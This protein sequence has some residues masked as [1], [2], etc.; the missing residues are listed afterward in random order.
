MI[1]KNTETEVYR[2][3]YCFRA[4][5]Y[6]LHRWAIWVS[7]QSGGP[8][9][10][11]WLTLP[12]QGPTAMFQKRRQKLHYH[13]WSTLEITQHPSSLFYWWK[14][15]LKSSGQKACQ[16][17][18]RCVFKPRQFTFWAQLY[19]QNSFTPFPR[20]L[21]FHYIMV[22]GLK[23]RIFSSK[24]NPSVIF[25]RSSS[26]DIGFW[27]QSLSMCKNFSQLWCR[28]AICLSHIPNT[29]WWD[30][31][32]IT[33]VDAPV[34]KGENKKHDIVTG[35]CGSEIQLGMCCQFLAEAQSF[36]QGVFLCGSWL[37][38]LHSWFYPLSHFYF[39]IKTSLFASE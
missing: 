4:P 25:F 22:S 28:V 32:R 8:R 31:Y 21:R 29:Q 35:P 3:K 2:Q 9:A 38:S 1:D 30:R 10:V 37:H 11:R 6:N 33:I 23:F 39:T 15:F 24:S 34:Y 26:L 13:L 14:Q 27:V 17:D 5:L 7:S 16:S 19:K 18:F 20:P 36:Y 12:A